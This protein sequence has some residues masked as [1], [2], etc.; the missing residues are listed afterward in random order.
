MQKKV[1]KRNT[2]LETYE[3]KKALVSQFNLTSDIFFSKVME[4][5]KACEEVIRI[6]TEENFS[7]KKVKTQYS[8]RNMEAHSVVLDVLDENENGCLVSIEIHPQENENHVKRVRYN[9]SCIDTSF[10]EKGEEYKNVPETYMLHITENDFIGK[11][12]GINVVNRSICGETKILDNGVH[13][14]YVILQGESDD[15]EQKELLK[16]LLKS[17]SDYETEAFPNLVA[18]VKLFKEQKEGIDV[19]C[20]I[21]ERERMMAREEGL[22]EGEI[23]GKIALVRKKYLKGNTSEQVADALELD[24]SY[25]KNVMFMIVEGLTDEEIAM[26]LISKNI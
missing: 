24:Q 20:E 11:N 10:F 1:G 14:I 17:D 23:K 18:R 4:D 5:M 13:E 9:L 22:I 3:E 26:E 12:N 6:F 21:I 8:I 25:I 7:V 2:R 15:P 16:Y 19:M